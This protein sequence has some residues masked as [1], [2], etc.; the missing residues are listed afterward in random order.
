MTLSRGKK[1]K[2]LVMD[3]ELSD[4]LKVSLFMKD[5]IKESINLFCEELSAMV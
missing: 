5:Y 3:I 2:F 1:H 4:N